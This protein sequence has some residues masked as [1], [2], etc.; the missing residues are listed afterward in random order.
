MPLSCRYVDTLALTHQAFGLADHRITGSARQRRRL[1][2]VKLEEDV[3]VHSGA[4][5][6]DRSPSGAAASS[7]PMQSCWKTSRPIT[8]VVGVPG[9]VKKTGIRIEDYLPQGHAED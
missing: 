6:T 7:A 2:G 5:I 8:L 4:N 3:I 9:T 1:E